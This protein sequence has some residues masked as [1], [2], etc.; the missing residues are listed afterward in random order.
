MGPIGKKFPGGV[1]KR[2]NDWNKR[3]NGDIGKRRQY[4]E[5]GENHPVDDNVGQ[6]KRLKVFNQKQE[7]TNRPVFEDN[8]E[9][10]SDEGEG[11]NH[12][13]VSC[14]LATFNADATKAMDSDEEEESTDGDN[15]HEDTEEFVVEEE[16]LDSEEGISDEMCEIESDEEDM[17][18]PGNQ[19][20]SEKENEAEEQEDDLND[21]E[22]P[23]NLH[24]E[25]NINETQAE[26][27]QMGKWNS[28]FQNWP[29]LGRL[30]VESAEVKK[31]TSKLLLL[32]PKEEDEAPSISVLPRIPV[33]NHYNMDQQYLKQ[34][35]QKNISVANSL[36]DSHCPSS[37]TDLQ[38]EIFAVLQNYSDFYF[39]K[40]TFDKWEEIR[41]VYCLHVVNH[42]LK[43]RVR[44]LHHNSKINK[45]KK[46][47]KQDDATEYRDQGY[48]RPKV[49][50]LL[51]FRHSAFRV[52]KTIIALIFGSEEKGE[53][54]Q[55]K[56]R[57]LEE[58]GCNTSEDQQHRLNRPDDFEAL[59][60]GDIREDFKIGLTLTK[61][62]LKLY[63][64]FYGS[65]IIIASPMGLRLTVGVPGERDSDTDF[66]SSVEVMVI[67]QADAL[68]MQNWEHMMILMKSINLPPRDIH[69]LKVDLNRIRLWSLDGRSTL[70][71]QT[72]LFSSTA[73]DHHRALITKCRN[74]TSRIQVLNHEESGSVQQVLVSAEIIFNRIGNIRDPD[75]RFNHFIKEVIPQY[76]TGLR[77]HTLIYIPDYC[78]YIRL[79]KH[80]KEEGISAA[81]INEYMVG[82][83]SKVAKARCLFFEGKRPILLYTERFHFYR[84]YRIKGIRHIIFYDLPNYPHFFSELCNL[85]M[86]GNQNPRQRQ[87]QVGSKTVLVLYQ[88]PDV[89]KLIGVVGSKRATEMIKSDKSV[90]A[91][92]TGR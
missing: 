21:I 31:T 83:N 36:Q 66:L 92:A 85:M 86:E 62:S 68:L 87:K 65:D 61:K 13:A 72:V 28:F 57:F 52:V 60:A 12:D 74:F 64:D 75:M 10:S 41:T 43:T 7:E 20:F 5:F 70:Y 42:I 55:N 51:P 26:A 38:K 17:I 34:V 14:L 89:T 54:I 80:F 69:K 79:V 88:K 84:R 27:I 37:L 56:K 50:I 9:E 2:K 47:N 46:E 23:F 59:F 1:G 22:D 81:T 45:A 77:A 58:F 15:D 11:A 29:N 73:M 18:T 63:T 35:L 44:I 19:E 90:H 49:L 30:K 6:T 3:K 25:R 67:D 40:S 39:P 53:D 24:F 4:E 48:A 32:D 71:R 8:E 76:V 78:D 33:Q 82:K 91:C 16:C